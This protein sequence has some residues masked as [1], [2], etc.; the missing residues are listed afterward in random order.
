MNKK[1]II[2]IENYEGFMKIYVNNIVKSFL[3]KNYK[4]FIYSKNKIKI[5]NINCIVQK[6]LDYFLKM[7][8]PRIY[9]KLLLFAKKQSIN[10]IFLPRFSF[11]EY[12]Y[13]S[14]I[15]TRY[16]Y[17]IYLST[18]AFEL[19]SK[20][21]GRLAILKKLLLE[22]K[23]K[24]LIIHSVLNKYLEIPKKFRI[25]QFCYYYYFNF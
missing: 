13:S 7:H 3:K 6:D 24:F 11:P 25:R 1:I 17:K 16:K 15:S 22:K 14:I 21:I 23:I 2:F 5:K 12:L 19:F 18:F 9:E 8:D 4:I 10:R 20:S